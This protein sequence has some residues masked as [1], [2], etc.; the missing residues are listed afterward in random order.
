MSDGA[1]A[2][3][4]A[5]PAQGAQARGPGGGGGGMAR[6][7]L[8]PLLVAEAVGAPLRRGA[9]VAL[10]IASLGYGVVAEGVRPSSWRR[11]SVRA[12]F[13]RSLRQALDG[14]LLTML[15]TAAIVGFSM[16]YQALY[17]LELAGDEGLL[18]RILVLVL[19]RETTPVLVGL[20]LLGR[21]GTVTMAEFGEIKAQGQLRMLEGQGIDPFGL[22]VMPRTVAYA[23]A[24][25]SLGMVFLAV[26]LVCGYVLAS[27]SGAGPVS[28]ERFLDNLVQ[29][30]GRR[31]F[32]LLAGK[33]V[34]IGM[35][36]ALSSAVTGLSATPHEKPSY[37]LPRGFVRGLFAVLGTSALLSLAA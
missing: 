28:L 24:S 18:S 34:L 11:R 33:L 36:V 4:D 8:L 26:A 19:V 12:E 31:D 5:R 15:V 7:A 29:A 30:T 10:H 27:A 3:S 25:F 17:W 37:L 1:A 23:V 32:A 14:G 9:N 16:V 21:S 6:L 35:L 20:V 22:L 13:R 2:A